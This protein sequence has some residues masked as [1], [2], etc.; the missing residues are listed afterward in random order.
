MQA[1]EKKRDFLFFSASAPF[2][3]TFAI[4]QPDGHSHPQ[5]PELVVGKP[6]RWINSAESY[7]N[8][9][10][11]ELFKSIRLDVGWFGLSL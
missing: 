3:E 1:K 6:P 5:D 9:D 4:T 11:E 8:V 2:C 10:R 7:S